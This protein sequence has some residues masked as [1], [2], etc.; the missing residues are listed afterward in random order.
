MKSQVFVKT[1]N[2]AGKVVYLEE[3]QKV[4]LG[5]GSQ[6][7]LVVL[8]AV[9]SRAHCT[10]HNRGNQCYVED[11]NSRNGTNVNGERIAGPC[12]L[13]SGDEIR[14]GQ[15][16][17]TVKV[18]VN[19][20]EAA[21]EPAN[22]M[23][24]ELLAPVED[25]RSSRP[26]QAVDPRK[27]TISPEAGVALNQKATLSAPPPSRAVHK[28]VNMPSPAPA[29]SSQV[30]SGGDKCVRCG[31]VIAVWESQ[32]QLARQD[33]AGWTCAN[34]LHPGKVQELGNYRLVQAIGKGQISTVY[35]ARHARLNKVVA[36]KVL[37]PSLASD[38]AMV[39]K[40]LREA[41]AGGLLCHPNIV[42]LLD[43][44]EFHSTYFIAMEWMDGG[45]LDQVVDRDGK[46]T[47]AQT[48]QVLK[49]VA[50]ALEHTE[51]RNMIHRDL[52]PENVLVDKDFNAKLKD[53]GKARWLEQSGMIS[54]TQSTTGPGDMVYMSPEMVYSPGTVD[55]RSDLYSMGAIGIFALTGAPPF[56]VRNLATLITTLRSEEPGFFSAV[57]AGVPP[58]LV[59]FLRK[60]VAKDPKARFQTATEALHALTAIS[61][62]TGSRKAS[63]IDQAEQ[64]EL[65]KDQEDI[66]RAKDVQLKLIPA[67]LP[68]IASYEM[69]KYYQPAKAVGGDYFDFFP[70][71][72][73]QYAFV[74]A[75]V[76]GK[77]LAGA[78]VMVMVRSI[79]RA[80]AASGGN[81]AQTLIEVNRS[82]YRDIRRGMFVSAILGFLDPAQDIVRFANA[83]HNPPLFWEERAGAA[84]FVED[85]GL[86]L[87]MTDGPRFQ[88][89]IKEVEVKLRRGDMMEFYTDGVVEAMN[90]QE[91]EFGTD[92]LVMAAE[93]IRQ[94]SPERMVQR[95]VSAIERHAAG[96]EQSD[97][98][99]IFVM[100]R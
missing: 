19:Q 1:G 58:Q 100:K 17:L 79:F 4:T 18:N 8:D 85:H 77:G 9:I 56:P 51:E 40:F 96:A 20:A 39:L 93:S 22:E 84:R 55:K 82:L 90:A 3:G 87:G 48:V 30:S 37:D 44:G 88:N 57:P 23:P 34:C 65:E 69:A 6:C 89:E 78:M 83:G 74:V 86:V 47:A 13:K 16:V 53:F 60:C 59:E 5:R 95:L 80:M 99:T 32:E 41:R 28:T 52:K 92:P 73:G 35:R 98:I 21:A 70:T 25:L 67:S 81:A 64:A 54:M 43:A 7:D 38:E 97:D 42:Q 26:A 27:L 63:N 14:L 11:L 24:F 66:M 2:L 49:Q 68:E 15:T 62:G 76:S 91:V 31:R 33:A 71:V 46:L 12:V 72:N 45:P 94:E 61:Q 29:S 75:D 36:L 10:V 50:T